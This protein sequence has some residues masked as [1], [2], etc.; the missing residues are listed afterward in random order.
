MH[1]ITY[2]VVM[3]HFE[4][5]PLELLPGTPPIHP[6]ALSKIVIEDGVPRIELYADISHY[7]A[8]PPPTMQVQVESSSAIHPFP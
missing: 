5:R 8:A 4:G 6:T 2:K 1:A 3:A 7:Q